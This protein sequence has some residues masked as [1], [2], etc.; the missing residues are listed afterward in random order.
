MKN[1]GDLGGCYLLH[2]SSQDTQPHALIVKYF[3]KHCFQDCNLDACSVANI[4][5]G[6]LGTRVN[7]DRSRTR[8]DVEIF[9]SGKKKLRIQKMHEYVWTGP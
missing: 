5:R 8:V 7:P 4:P 3:Y 9:D 6:V 1:Q 2:N